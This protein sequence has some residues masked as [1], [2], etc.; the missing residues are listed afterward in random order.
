M[1]TTPHMAEKYKPTA[2]RIPER[3][4][5]RI[6]LVAKHE[7]V[8]PHG[9]TVQLI[10]EA[11]AAR[12]FAPSFVA[13]KRKRRKGAHPRPKPSSDY[14]PTAAPGRRQPAPI[15]LKG[16]RST[17]KT[18]QPIVGLDDPGDVL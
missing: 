9:M 7:K 4:K 5:D 11:L 13:P 2:V 10:E 18:P 14:I 8:T 17:P 16:R 6:A 15:T 12:G 3:T 1:C